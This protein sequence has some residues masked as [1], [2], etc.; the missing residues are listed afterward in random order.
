MLYPYEF[1]LLFTLYF[2]NITAFHLTLCNL[3]KMHATKYSQFHRN[4]GEKSQLNE[5]MTRS[6]ILQCQALFKRVLLSHF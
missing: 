6:D 3:L 1:P 2:E 5:K 4:V